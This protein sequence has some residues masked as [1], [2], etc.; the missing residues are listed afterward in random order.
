MEEVVNAIVLKSIPFIEKQRIVRLFSLERGF[1]SMITPSF[2]GRRDATGMARAMQVV[3][4]EYVASARGGLHSLRSIRPT[5]D[6]NAIAIDL[7]KMNIALLW[8]EVLSLVLR[9]ETRDEPLYD[10]LCRSVEYL[11]AAT[12][13]VANF[14]LFFFYRLC[15]LLGLRIDA[16]SY[17][18]GFFFN[19]RDGLFCPPG[20]ATGGVIGQRG[21]GTIYRLCRDPLHA[22][23]EIPLNRQGR[24]ILLD[25]V[26][27]F[28]GYHLDVDFNTKSIRVIR[29]V[30]D[31]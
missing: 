24:A 21:A 27:A 18:E 25:A 26:F 30:F 2:P 7:F 16:S 15:D 14:N 20:E 12:G 5:R 31:G 4:V 23:R 13:D 22:I 29:E 9:H 11:D 17:R 10:Y 1:L 3:E 19:P 28:I 8:G 6:T